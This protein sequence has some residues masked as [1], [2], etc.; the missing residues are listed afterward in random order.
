MKI[1]KYTTLMLLVLQLGFADVHLTLSNY[2][3]SASTVDVNYTS[4]QEL[5]PGRGYWLRAYEAGVIT[6]ASGV[7]AKI[8]PRDFSL[9]G[10]ANSLIINGI[11]LYFGIEISDET[12]PWG[13]VAV[14]LSGESILFDV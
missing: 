12:P 9:K 2:N 14:E 7:S 8:A 1:M 11:E 6:L 13:S 4:D 10:K 3:E 5:V